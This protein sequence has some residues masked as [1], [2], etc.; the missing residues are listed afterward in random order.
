MNT[1]W[2]DAKL[3][4]YLNRYIDGYQPA[5]NSTDRVGHV[6]F[7][8]LFTS[9]GY[10]QDEDGSF[11]EGPT[12]IANYLDT[13]W[14]NDPTY[15][16]RYSNIVGSTYSYWE[17]TKERVNLEL[18]V[19]WA[20]A[21]VQVDGYT[22]AGDNSIIVITNKTHG[23]V[24]GSTVTLTN[25]GFV[26]NGTYTVLSDD[27]TGDH[28]PLKF[29]LTGTTGTVAGAF[30]PGGHVVRP[31]REI[32]ECWKVDFEGNKIKRFQIFTDRRAITY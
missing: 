3:V 22:R 1:S 21:H 2:N 14:N 6:G 5:P 30:T 26:S 27:P 4:H 15:L 7:A 28:S 8:S 9:D 18:K 24:P 31:N 17:G 23:L 16:V 11:A 19:D 29:S 12:D 20:R 10:F 25:V 32:V 13:E